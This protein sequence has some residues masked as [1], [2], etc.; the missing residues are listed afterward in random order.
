MHRLFAGVD[1]PQAIKDQLLDV[2]EGVGGAR[3]QTPEQLHLTLRFIGEVD[4]RTAD[5]VAAA[6]A[7]LRHPRFDVA[8]AGVGCF[9]RRGRPDA[10]WVGLAPHPPLR[11]LHDKV[12]RALACAGIAP[13]GRA[14]L[15]HITVARLKGGGGAI[16]GWV[17]RF[18]GV[19]SEPWPVDALTLWES[20]LG[21]AGA[22]YEPVGAWRLR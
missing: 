20:R 7:G 9:D 12:D 8:L 14:Y 16:R 13:E 3:W 19:T 11:T 21:S 2:Q 5:D 15:P 18:G 22:H 10:L 17:E 1:P 6:L 4:G